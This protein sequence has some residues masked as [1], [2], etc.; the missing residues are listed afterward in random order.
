VK[1]NKILWYALGGAALWWLFSKR[2]TGPGDD[3][4]AGVGGGAPQIFPT[5]P[6]AIGLA[7]GETPSFAAALDE[8][9]ANV[10]AGVRRAAERQAGGLEQQAEDSEELVPRQALAWRPTAAPMLP[11]EAIDL[12]GSPCV[13]PLRWFRPVRAGVAVEPG[14]ANGLVI[15]N[16]PFYWTRDGGNF[17]P[18][19]YL[20]TFAPGVAIVMSP[21]RDRLFTA[22]DFRNGTIVA[23]PQE[24]VFYLEPPAAQSWMNNACARDGDWTEQYVNLRGGMQGRIAGITQVLHWLA[25]NWRYYRPPNVAQSIVRPAAPPVDWSFTWRNTATVDMRGGLV[26]ATFAQSTRRLSFVGAPALE[27]VRVSAVNTNPTIERGRT[28]GADASPARR[29]DLSLS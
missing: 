6:G 18:Y 5:G 20:R 1:D 29:F 14:F 15:Q 8:A 17:S 10:V 23:N 7:G 22:I 9:I 19:S 2:D 21:L 11:V 3:P 16:I 25:S 24:L 4:G 12:R 26:T 28:R 13:G 27:P